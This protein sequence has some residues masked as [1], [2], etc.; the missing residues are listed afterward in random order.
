MPCHDDDDCEADWDEADEA[1]RPVG[2]VTCPYCRQRI[3]DGSEQ[4]P[5]C[6]EYISEEEA[7]TRNPVWVIVC[8]VLCSRRRPRLGRSDAEPA[9]AVAPP[10][11]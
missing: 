5:R 10:L 3:F 6:E 8:A 1:D 2:M 7:P 11:P 9:L 4:C